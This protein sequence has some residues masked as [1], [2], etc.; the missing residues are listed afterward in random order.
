[1]KYNIIWSE[2]AKKDYW[3]NIEYL[4]EFWYEKQV[5]NFINEVDRHLNIIRNN[6][7]TFAVTK[8]R[9]VRSVPVVKQITLFY[10][11]ANDNSIEL[12]RFWNNYQNPDKLKI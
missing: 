9:N 11:I 4:L 12:V 1:M 5:Q 3:Q 8:Y 6:P 10:R 7:K 2:P